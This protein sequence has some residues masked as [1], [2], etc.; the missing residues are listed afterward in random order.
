MK[1]ETPNMPGVDFAWVQACVP[2]AQV[3]ERMGF[4]PRK[5]RGDQLRG[6]CPVHG[7]KSPRSRSFSV[8]LRKGLCHCHRCGFGGNQI[9]LWAKWRGLGVY[10]AAIDLCRQARIEV[11]W[12]ERW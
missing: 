5:V 8:H 3:L 2:M 6:P 1:Q 7:S 12:I 11:P 9:Q 4:V 10:E